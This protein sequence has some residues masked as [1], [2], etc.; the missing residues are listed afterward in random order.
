[1]I[2][3]RRGAGRGGWEQRVLRRSK[4][5]AMLAAEASRVTLVSEAITLED[6]LKAVGEQT[7][8]EVVD[9]REDIDQGQGPSTLSLKLN[10]VA[11]W[12][13]LDEICR[14][15][16]T[17]YDFYIGGGKLGVRRQEAESFP[18]S[19]SGPLRIM[20]RT[21]MLKQ[22]LAKGASRPTAGDGREPPRTGTGFLELAG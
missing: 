15:S 13:A 12:Q 7:G 17:G 4:R 1:M 10:G 19:Y 11:F 3:E 18:V 5:A 20:A 8:N 2:G 6:A 16:G 22:S 21:V 14:A 9:L